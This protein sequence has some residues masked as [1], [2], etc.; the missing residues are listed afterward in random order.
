MET[1]KQLLKNNHSSK[2]LR[3]D[4]KFGKL[5]I[6]PPSKDDGEREVKFNYEKSLF[7]LEPQDNAEVTS[8][9]KSRPITRESLR[10][11]FGSFKRNPTEIL[12]VRNSNS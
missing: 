4:L 5:L 3:L 8:K 1:A 2:T 9:S 7:S 12:S 11:K 6:N 10:K